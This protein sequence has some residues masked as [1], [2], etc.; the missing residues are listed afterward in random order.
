MKLTLKDYRGLIYE[1]IKRVYKEKEV[2]LILQ[3]S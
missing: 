3:T 2:S 1:H